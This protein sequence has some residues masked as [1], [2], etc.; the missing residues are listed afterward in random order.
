MLCDPGHM[1]SLA[2]LVSLCVGNL[3]VMAAL[4]AGCA[5][6][7]RTTRPHWYTYALM[8]GRAS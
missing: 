7:A 6:C 1:V 4:D 3:S 2:W 5:G 8:K